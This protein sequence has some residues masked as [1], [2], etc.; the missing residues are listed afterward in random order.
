M[1]PTILVVGATGTT[2]TK[3]VEE[4]RRRPGL[5]IRTATRAAAAP[6]DLPHHRF[7]WFDT[8]TWR[9]AVDGVDRMYLMAPVGHPDPVALVRPFAEVAVAAGVRRVVLL[10]SSAVA[11][12]DPGLGAVDALVRTTF[13]E[14]GVLR[15]TW[16][17]QN[18][19][20]DHPLAESIR[21]AGEFITATGDGRL[22]FID[23]GDIGRSAAVLLAADR[24]ANGEHVLTGP[25]ALN[26]DE[27]AAVMSALTGRRV[28]HRAVAPECY[29]D[30]L[31]DAGYDREFAAGLV[32]LDVLVAEGTE[33]R[34]TDTVAQL[35]GAPP[36][37]FERFLRDQGCAG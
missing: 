18:F 31:V 14:W 32:A 20:G 11:C 6:T 36:R 25:R 30:R 16:F 22:P 23:A 10:S 33:A 12:G 4:L 15:P 35:T 9:S 5:A 19:V 21:A 1:S 2:G 28:T 27:A 24:L 8:A 13:P 29:V 17:M 26:Y 37:S 7:D 3:V 34:V